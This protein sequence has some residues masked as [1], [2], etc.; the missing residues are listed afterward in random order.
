[1]IDRLLPGLL[2]TANG[3][4]NTWAEAWDLQAIRQDRRQLH[5]GPFQ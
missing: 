1:M 5:P 3:S 2:R 4:G